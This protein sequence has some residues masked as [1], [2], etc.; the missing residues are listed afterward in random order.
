MPDP[1]ENFWPDVLLLQLPDSEPI[2][3][4]KEQA[5][6]L[7]ERT[8]GRVI[9]TVRENVINDTVYFSLYLKNP[10]RREKTLAERV[11]TNPGPGGEDYGFEILHVAHPL[12]KGAADPFSLQAQD[13][14]GGANVAVSSM[15]EF[16]SW[17]KSV[18]TS[19]RVIS[20]IGNL[21]RAA[22]KPVSP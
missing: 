14:F 20:V 2:H 4:L 12:T 16:K 5:G 3:F 6:Y 21:M 13:S 10:Q 18:L 17:L 7:G 19:E 15:D 1:V 22:K 9:G 11:L 8:Q